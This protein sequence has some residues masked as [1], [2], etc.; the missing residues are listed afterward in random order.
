MRLAA[1]DDADQSG[2]YA[3]AAELFLGLIEASSFP[4]FLTLA[5]YELLITGLT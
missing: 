4:E 3:D 2:R 5:A 1:G